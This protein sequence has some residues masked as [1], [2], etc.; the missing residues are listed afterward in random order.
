MRG[1]PFRGILCAT[2]MAQR[3]LITG[4]GTGIGLHIARGF[5]EQGA[6]VFICGS[7]ARALHVA[8]KQSPELKFM[9]CDVSRRGDVKR[10]VAAAAKILGGLD[11][12][13]NNAGIAG[14]TSSVEKTDPKEWDKTLLVNLTGSFNVA[15]LCIP[16]L[17]RSSGGSIINISS[18]AGKF[19]YPN[20]GPYAASKW[21]LIGLT[22]T[23]S[24]EL[25]AHGIR[26]NAI[27]PGAVESSRVQKVYEDRA[28]LT[29]L[30]VKEVREASMENQSIKGLIDPRE[31]AA[32]AVFIAS[33]KGRSISGQMLAI[34]ND[35][36][37]MT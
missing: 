15:R 28:K 17:K 12:L 13:V 34:D 7:N 27:L 1:H 11:V 2:N 32:L 31:V 10:M 16:H 23:L 18:V 6:K 30:S 20:R 8:A 26:V 24:M 22:K 25:G 21:G 19:G 14:S 5:L 36:Q 37:R 35:R 4:G 3:V 29:G 33:E 9:V